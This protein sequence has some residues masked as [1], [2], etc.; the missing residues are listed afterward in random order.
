MRMPRGGGGDSLWDNELVTNVAFRARKCAASTNRKPDG[1][2]WVDSILKVGEANIAYRLY[3]GP[4]RSDQTPLLVYFHANAELCTDIETEVRSFYECG[5]PV[6]L[7]PEFRG[8]AWGTGRPKITSMKD[9]ARAF[10]DALPEILATAG[11]ERSPEQRV[12]AHGRSL[13]AICAV[14]VASQG[15]TQ[16]LI[17]ESGCMSILGLPMVQELGSMMPDMLRMLGAA[18]DPLATLTEMQQVT[19][20]T[21]IIHGDRDEI[22]PVGQAVQAHKRCTSNAK[23]LVRYSRS[24]H[25]DLRSMARVAYFEEIRTF[26]GVVDG[27]LPVETMLRE[28]PKPPGFFS[29]LAGAL[30]CLPGARRCLSDKD[31]SEEP[32]SSA[33]Q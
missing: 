9:D 13:G 21:L 27:S 19:V 10:M 14:H 22:V 4:D 33:D 23:R 18:P 31:S 2:G 30:R 25:N 1:S 8:Y 16:G 17:V 26:G 6:I 12:V 24:S 29:A 11:V 15:L 20:P 5:F 7:C 28:D 32:S 3:M